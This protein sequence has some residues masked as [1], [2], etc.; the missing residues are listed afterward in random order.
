MLGVNSKDISNITDYPA[1][2]IL[3]NL[4]NLHVALIAKIK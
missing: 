1:Y 4:L 3:C 2:I